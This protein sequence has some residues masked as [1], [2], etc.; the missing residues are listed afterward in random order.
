MQRVNPSFPPH[1]DQYGHSTVK[2]SK[3]AYLSGLV[4]EPLKNGDWIV[5]LW[6]PNGKRSPLAV[7]L[8]LIN[9]LLHQAVELCCKDAPEPVVGGVVSKFPG[10]TGGGGSPGSGLLLPLITDGCG[11]GS[12]VETG[13]GDEVL[14]GSKDNQAIEG[15]AGDGLTN[16]PLWLDRGFND[17][18]LLCGWKRV[19]RNLQ[20]ARGKGRSSKQNVG[21]L[22][23]ESK[24]YREKRGLRAI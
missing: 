24:K 23:I 19:G 7:C 15:S 3:G 1:H 16:S 11:D 12:T 14:V 2:I 4:E 9:S 20:I 5:L 13:L 10:V 8:N 17:L 6:Q 21:D 22:H 18:S